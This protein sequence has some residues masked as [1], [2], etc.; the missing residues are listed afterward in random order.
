VYGDKTWRNAKTSVNFK[1]LQPGQFMLWGRLAFVNRSSG[2]INGYGFTLQHTGHWQLAKSLNKE[3]LAKGYTPTLLNT[4]Y[5]AELLTVQDSIIVNLDG[6]RLC[7]V[8]DTYSP[9]GAFGAGFGINKGALDNLA[10]DSIKGLALREKVAQ[11]GGGEKPTMPRIAQPIP[12]KNAV[13]VYWS[14]S[15]NVDYYLVEIGESDVKFTGKFNVGKATDYTFTTLKSGKP[16]WFRVTAF[17][18]SGETTCQGPQK[19]VPE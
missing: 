8:K 6:K 18:T 7:A 12:L 13:K 17:N 9:Y 14:E 1:L 16:Y 10:V 3:V 4:W 11:T 5:K 15:A 2:E 19:G